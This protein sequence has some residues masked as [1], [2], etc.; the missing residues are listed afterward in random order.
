[1]QWKQ[2]S[3]V[4]RTLNKA[5]PLVNASDEKAPAEIKTSLIG[6]RE[7]RIRA[8]ELTLTE[9]RRDWDSLDRSYKT[10][11]VKIVPF[12]G[13]SF[14]LLSYL[15][16][17]NVPQNYILREKLFIPNQEYGA[18]IYVISAFL[19]SGRANVC[20]PLTF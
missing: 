11:R 17:T 3:K 6:S 1:M 19:L 4:I 2:L 14:D 9:Q 15:Y 8:L 18:V 16:N 10:A 7:D 12:S 5:M 13:A 20:T